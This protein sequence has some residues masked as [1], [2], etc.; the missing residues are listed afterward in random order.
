VSIQDPEPEI[1]PGIAEDLNIEGEEGALIVNVYEDS[2]AE[3]G[4]LLPG[5]FVIQVGDVDIRDAQHFSRIIGNVSPGEETELTLIR[6]GD[7]ETISVNLDERKTE[8]ALQEDNNIWPGMAVIGLTDRVKNQL[9]LEDVKNGAVVA[10]VIQDT[11]AAVAGLRSGDVITAIN[12]EEVKNVLDF[13]QL[14]NTSTGEIMFKI[15]REG[16]EVLLGVVK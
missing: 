15:H 9:D 12:K 13:Y 4:G 16:R 7:V 6:Y 14:L 10:S 3:R 11:P 5:D 2:P 8:E 1:M